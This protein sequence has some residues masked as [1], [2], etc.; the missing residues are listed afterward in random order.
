MGRLWIPDE[1]IDLHGKKLGPYGVAVYAVLA[2]HSDANGDLTCGCR[3]VAML[4]G[5][6][7]KAANKYIQLLADLNLII[8]VVGALGEA[9]TIH[10][11]SV[12]PRGTLVKKAY[13]VGAQSVPPRGTLAY[14]LGVHKEGTRRIKEG[15]Q[16]FSLGVK[17]RG[18]LGTD[19]WRKALPGLAKKTG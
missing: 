19:K 11:K 8:R 5:I 7:V 10:L 2:R 16:G 17:T 15:E 12:P 9:S 18:T 6:T 1:I 14:P 3:R 4:L 13:P